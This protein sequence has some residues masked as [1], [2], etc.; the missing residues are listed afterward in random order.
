MEPIKTALGDLTKWFDQ[1]FRALGGMVIDFIHS[2]ASGSPE[3]ALERFTAVAA[4]L[5]PA[6][7]AINIGAQILEIVHPIK[8][9]GIVATVTSTLDVMGI[10]PFALGAIALLTTA[11]LEKP[12]RQGLAYRYRPEIPSTDMADQ[13]LM[14]RNLDATEWSRIYALHGWP[15]KYIQAWYKTLWVEPSDR[16]I[17]GM[18][19]G[20]DIDLNWLE[21]KLRERGYT[22]IDAAYIM[23][24]ATRKALANEISAIT[25]EINADVY[26]GQID[27][28]EAQEELQA[29]GYRGKELEFRMAAMKRRLQRKDV[30]DKIEILTARVK[31]EEITVAQYES[32]LR[33]LGLRQPR[34]SALVEK[35][36]LRRKPKVTAPKEQKRD[37]AASTY[38]RL[39]VEDVIETEDQLRGYLEALTPAYP[40]DRI[41]LLVLDAKIRKAKAT[42]AS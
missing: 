20:G 31:A 9:M 2:I 15:D 29:I 32:E 39:F 14:E 3:Q 6:V 21:Q 41:E 28:L 26:A 30:N 27:L 17:V 24:Y 23:R 16:M 10:R 36:E 37:L 25:S 4:I 33:A 5:G 11:A 19:E 8:H 18:V 12:I 22:D 42:A 7:T 34:I 1:Q 40:A 38:Q 13:M 35:E